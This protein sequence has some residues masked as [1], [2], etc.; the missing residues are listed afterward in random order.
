MATVIDG[1]ILE[2]RILGGYGH[3]WRVVLGLM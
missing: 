1:C 3:V 2:S